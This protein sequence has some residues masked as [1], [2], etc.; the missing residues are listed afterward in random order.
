MSGDWFTSES[1]L[2][3]LERAIRYRTRNGATAEETL[4]MIRTIRRLRT[5]IRRLVAYEEAAESWVF[6]RDDVGRQRIEALVRNQVRPEQRDD[7]YLSWLSGELAGL[8]DDEWERVK[9]TREQAG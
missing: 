4:Q 3:R 2:K 5:A 6:H 7:G 1:N 8:S 9:R